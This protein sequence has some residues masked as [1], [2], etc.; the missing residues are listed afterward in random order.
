M[1][2]IPHRRRLIMNLT[3]RASNDTRKN[4]RDHSVQDQ[5][6]KYAPCTNDEKSKECSDRK[7]SNTV[8]ILRVI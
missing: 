5:N 7:H 2:F 8:V 3:L 6:L 4:Y 1:F